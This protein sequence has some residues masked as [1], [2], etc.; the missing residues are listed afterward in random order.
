MKHNPGDKVKIYTDDETYE[1]IIMPSIELTGKDTLIL[2]LE[3]NGYNIGF[4]KKKIK[5]VELVQKYKSEPSKEKKI[6]N[7]KDLPTISILHTG[8]TIASKLD[9][10]T[11][12]V[13]SSFT[14]EE[15]LNMFPELK[16]MVNIRS[17]L[18]KN[19]WSQDMRFSHYNIL[20]KEILKEIKAGSQGIIITHG[21]DTIHYSSSALSFILEDLS[22][23]VLIVGAQRSSD[24]GSS[25]AFINLLNA[26]YFIINS[27]FSEVGVCMHASSNDNDCWIHSG[28]KVRKFHSSRRDA[29][30][31]VNQKVWAAVDYQKN[32]IKYFRKGYNKKSDSLP[33]LKLFDEKIKVGLIKQRTNMFGDE[34]LFYKNYDG[35]VIEAT[36]LACLPISEIDDLTTESGKIK[37]A[38]KKIIDEGCVVVNAPQ[39]I[40]GRINMNVYEDQR[41]AQ[42]MGVLG[43][44]NDMTPAT[45]YIKL[46][47]LLSNYKKEDISELIIK[48][49]R[50]EINDKLTDDLFMKWDWNK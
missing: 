48:N 3:K 41:N 36:G 26:V 27:D 33:K 5:K 10:Q 7:N 25:D 46:A 44:M 20:A 8:G 17:R 18:V 38:I 49:L 50:G 12:G 32:K 39:T 11:G 28:T 43:S 29:F 34:F 4:D 23:P 21:T 24:R 42:N 2:K 45:T 6:V 16:S 47:W 14:P 13:G 40:F 9:Y 31:P 19:M 37:K 30:Q 15:I 1:G 35:L 22:K